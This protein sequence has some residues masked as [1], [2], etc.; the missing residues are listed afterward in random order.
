MPDLRRT[1]SRSWCR[2]VLVLVLLS[3][4]LVR[5]ATAASPPASKDS[6]ATYH[7]SASEVRLVL[8]ATDEHNRP[9][10]D[11]QQDDFAVIDNEWVIRSFRGF[12]G[13]K[14][15]RLDVII[16]LDSSE[17]NLP[18][19]RAQVAEVRQL[20]ELWPWAGEDRVSLISFGGTEPHVVCAETCRSS[21]PG[22]DDIVS[23]PH[24]GATPLFD[25]VFL[26]AR[27]LAQRRQPDVWPLIVLFSDGNDTV[28]LRSLPEA[29]DSVLASGAQVYGVDTSDPAHASSGTSLLQKLADDS[30]GR[31]L[32]FSAGTDTVLRNILDDLHSARV[33]T[34]ALPGSSGDFH[35]IRILPSRNLKLQFRCRSGYYQHSYGP[36]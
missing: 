10:E 18:R 26:A 29:L 28:S 35:A 9:V 14:E 30:G 19:F 2:G 20:V 23:R 34:Y 31:R 4:A 7:S 22:V 36:R 5:T 3:L 16:L 11:L 27:T 17:S 13:S 24:G 15:G 21:L 1:S 25:A 32:P 8:F 12:Y 33:V 6:S